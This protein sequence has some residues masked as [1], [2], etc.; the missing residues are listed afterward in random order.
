MRLHFVFVLLLV[1]TFSVLGC[2]GGGGGDGATDG[3]IEAAIVAGRFTTE[4]NTDQDL[5]YAYVKG[6]GIGGGWITDVNDTPLPG[7]SLTLQNLANRYERIM[8]RSVGGFP[9]PTYRLAYSVGGETKHLDANLSWTLVP[10]FLS[11]PRL[12]VDPTSGQVTIDNIQLDKG[13]GETQIRIYDE[14]ERFLW[15]ESLPISGL[16]INERL[17]AS[18][19]GRTAKVMVLADTKEGGVLKHRTIHL[20]RGRILY[21]Q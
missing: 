1:S 12:T 21:S 17:P 10:R 8:P 14:D 7:S 9:L 19:R 4:D 18:L 20:F 15:W 3:A 6:S 2:G 13:P 16:V 11:T 5:L